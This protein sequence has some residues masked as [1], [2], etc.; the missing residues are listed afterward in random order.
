MTNESHAE[1]E[2]A[3]ANAQEIIARQAEE[4]ENLRQ[5]LSDEDL[6]QDL[7]R[8]LALTTVSSVVGASVT[9]SQVLELIVKTAAE[10]TGARAGSLFLVSDDGRELVF[11]VAIGPKAEE[12]KAFRVPVGTG[13]AGL[14]AATGQPMIVSDAQHDPQHASDIA[15]SVGYL[16]Q[17]ILCVP[18]F[19]GDRVIGVLE[20]LDKDGKP[21]FNTE[22]MALL[23]LFANLAAVA[24]AQ[25]GTNRGLVSLLVEVLASAGDGGAAQTSDLSERARVFAARVQDDATFARAVELASL[26]QE[27]VFHGEPEFRACRAILAGFAEYI[28]SRSPSLGEAGRIS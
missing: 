18:L 15:R 17:A 21:S 20:M 2:G 5:R 19:Y 23:G 22:D 11:E 12:V 10:A 25:S 14:V 28:R 6:A 16:P 4:I 8:A 3:P 9:P 24:I 26:V 7:R 1:L 13:I 27:V